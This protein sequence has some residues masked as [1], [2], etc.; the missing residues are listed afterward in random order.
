[1]SQPWN[2]LDFTDIEGFVTIRDNDYFMYNMLFQENYL[3][4][5]AST[6]L[7]SE[8][9]PVVLKGVGKI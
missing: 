9:S 6:A 5:F 3:P 7:L 2:L 8:G 1:M 4:I